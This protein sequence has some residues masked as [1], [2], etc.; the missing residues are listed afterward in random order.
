MASLI[1]VT[2]LAIYTAANFSQV[3]AREGQV[4]I[5]ETESGNPILILVRHIGLGLA[6]F[7]FQGDTIARHNLPGRPVFDW[8]MSI[9]FGVGLGLMIIRAIRTRADTQVRPYGFVLIWL[10]V[11]ILPTVLA[12]DTPHFLRSIAMLP[13]LWLIPA[14]GLDWVSN[15]TG[16]K[17]P[18]RFTIVVGTI[19]LSTFLTSYDYFVRYVQSPITHYYF[20]A[21]ATDLAAEI[22]SRPGFSNRI[23]NRLWDNFASLRFL[24]ADRDGANAANKVQLAVWPYEPEAVRAAVMALPSGSAIRAQT[25]ALARGDLE[26]TPY[27]LYTLYVAEPVGAEPVTARFGEAVELRGTQV[28]ERGDEVFIRLDWSVS[29]PVNVDYHI[30]VHILTQAEVTAQWDGE[31]LNNQ[32]HF[33]WLRPGDV[34]QAEYVLPKG[35]QVVVGVYA[36]DGTPLG[37][38]VYL[39]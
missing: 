35:E 33:T 23:D 18:I 37:E 5:F 28:V 39:K 26:S 20:E 36:P 3:F 27:S 29:S 31:P 32:Y 4:S 1:V 12:E 8:V 38:P 7:N 9:F 14:L 15:L 34:L 21:A 19:A 17:R 13:V 10:A 30:F 6:M 16:L 24:I 2:P 25:G 11:T 22:N